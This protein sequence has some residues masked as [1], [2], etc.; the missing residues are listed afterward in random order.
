MFDKAAAVHT[1]SSGVSR[2]ML[3]SDVYELKNEVVSHICRAHDPPGVPG[4]EFGLALFPT[5]YLCTLLTSDAELPRT[6]KH[7]IHFNCV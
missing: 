2:G 7:R 4:S 3:T 5:I 6:A 1:S